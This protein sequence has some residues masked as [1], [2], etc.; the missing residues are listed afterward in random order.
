VTWAAFKPWLIMALIF[1]VG[2]VAGGSLVIAFHS[3]ALHNPPGVQQFKAHWMMHLSHRLNLTPDQQ[4]K[5]EPIIADAASR[6][7]A[8]HDEEVGELGQII[9]QTNEKIAL[10]LTPE[11]QALLKQMMSERPHDLPGRPRSW[12]GPHPQGPGP[13]FQ[14]DDRPPG[15]PPPPAP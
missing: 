10:V 14:H 6:I 8:K 4:A 5:I 13:G 7:Q 1:G 11:Q 12:G 15:S 2:M 9:D 3:E